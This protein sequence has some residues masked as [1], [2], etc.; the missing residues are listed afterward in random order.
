M[1]GLKQGCVLS[2]ILLCIYIAELEES[3][4]AMNIGGVKIRNERIWSLAY[5]DVIVLVGENREALIVMIGTLT[6]RTPTLW[7]MDEQF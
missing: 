4:K 3:F 5:A 7:K 2:P 1:K 6:R